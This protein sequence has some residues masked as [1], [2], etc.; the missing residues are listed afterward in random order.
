MGVRISLALLQLRDAR[1]V[2]VGI[3]NP[4]FVGS[5]PT[6]ASKLDLIVWSVKLDTMKAIALLCILC[7]FCYS[8]EYG[9]ASF[10]SIRTNGG[11]KTASGEP[12]C[13]NKFTVAHKTIPLGTMV[14][15]TNLSNGKHVYAKVTDR[16][17][18]IKGRVIDVSDVCAD[19]LRFR[20]KGLTKVKIEVI[21]KT[22]K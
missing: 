7:N 13:N 5:N 4:L 8:A 3:A 2:M 17:P 1:V 11:T 20:H 15:V 12:L 21:K 9:I 6:R 10:Y 22:K 19:V 16:G 14:K 18:Y